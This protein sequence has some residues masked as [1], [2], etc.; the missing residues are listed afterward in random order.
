MSYVAK[1]AQ[2]QTAPPDAVPVAYTQ[3]VTVLAPDIKSY[4]LRPGLHRLQAVS[5][6]TRPQ[7]VF[8]HQRLA[9]M[10]PSATQTDLQV[11]RQRVIYPLA[12]DASKLLKVSGFVLTQIPITLEPLSAA[13]RQVKP[14]TLNLEQYQPEHNAAGPQVLLESG[15]LV[16]QFAEFAFGAVL[17]DT[18]YSHALS[19]TWLP[20]AVA[21]FDAF[22]ARVRYVALQEVAQAKL[23]QGAY[24]DL[25]EI[26]W[27]NL[28]DPQVTVTYVQQSRDSIFRG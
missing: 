14:L 10:R 27:A 21:G 8:Y 20:Q 13:S 26:N 1:A 5:A 15:E 28:K 19:L 7:R 23:F 24:L 11:S 3:T 12:T 9:I 22:E 2:F 18:G 16:N 17:S 4:R 25:R 6:W